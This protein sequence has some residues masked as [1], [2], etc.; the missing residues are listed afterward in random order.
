MVCPSATSLNGTRMA[1]VG[2]DK[3]IGQILGSISQDLG[4][5]ANPSPLQPVS[6][7][8]VGKMDGERKKGERGREEKATWRNKEEREKRVGW[9]WGTYR[10]KKIE[11]VIISPV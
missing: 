3:K 4:C 7:F 2:F 10:E 6:I 1:G 11:N 9:I 5:S 8:D